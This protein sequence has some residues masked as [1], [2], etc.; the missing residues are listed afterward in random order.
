MVPSLPIY[1]FAK[2]WPTAIHVISMMIGIKTIFL[3][4][5]KKKSFK[6][7][8][9]QNVLHLVGPEQSLYFAMSLEFSYIALLIATG[10]V[11]LRKSY[12]NKF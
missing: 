12:P 9:G 1:Y 8:G 10:Y 7:G 4:S 2:L 11:N 5:V 6:G 3:V